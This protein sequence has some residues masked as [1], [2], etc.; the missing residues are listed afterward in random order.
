MEE[1]RSRSA[2]VIRF[3]AEART[4]RDDFVAHE[5]PLE[6]QVN[7]AGLVVTMRTPGD[8]LDLATGFL[9]AERII[10]RASDIASMRHCAS[11]KDA[12]AEDNILRVVL[13]EGIEVPFSKLKRNFFASSSCGV[14]GKATIESVLAVQ[15]R[16]EH[17][18]TVAARVLYD[19]PP[20]L[21]AAQ[22]TFDTT[23]GLHAAGFFS[24]EG[25]LLVLHEDI[26]RHNAVDKVIGAMARA[27]RSCED[28]VLLVSGRVGFEIV[29]KA[30][31]ARIGVLAGVSAPSSLA[32]RLGEDLGITII[33]FLRGTSMNVYAHADR[34]T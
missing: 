16:V 30:A 7:G 15:G 33:G 22:P 27:S 13:R 34:V 32:V 21:R 10:E 20:R 19:L 1:T 28:G 18:S 17:R 2:R 5:E 12:E 4:S 23:G 9:L 26:G 25:E 6:I 29:Q 11:V 24:A 31:A 14:C 3:E 8:D